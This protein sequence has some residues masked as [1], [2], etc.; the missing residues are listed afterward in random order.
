MGS[1]VTEVGMKRH[2]EDEEVEQYSMSAMSEEE[3]AR[4]EEHVL[5][6]DTCRTLLE[7]TDLY[8]VAMAEAARQIRSEGIKQPQSWMGWI[9]RPAWAVVL[10]ALVVAIGAVTADVLLKPEPLALVL[11]AM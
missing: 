2:V 1:L 9:F 6:C 11:Q 3:S 10:S 4:L 5:T 7:E 8:I